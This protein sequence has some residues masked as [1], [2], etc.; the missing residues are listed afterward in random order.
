MKQKEQ[1]IDMN[2]VIAQDFVDMT[3]REVTN[4]VSECRTNIQRG[5]R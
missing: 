3:L 1:R 4:L 5:I 2:D